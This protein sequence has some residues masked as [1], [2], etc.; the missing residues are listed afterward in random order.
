MCIC[1]WLRALSI[2]TAVTSMYL[3]MYVASS[4]TSLEIDWFRGGSVSILQAANCAALLQEED[5]L[6]EHGP[7]PCHR[8]VSGTQADC[9][10]NYTEVQV[11][12]NNFPPPR[13]WYAFQAVAQNAG[14]NKEKM[15]EENETT[16]TQL[17]KIVEEHGWKISKSMVKRARRTL[18]WTFHVSRYCHL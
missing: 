4:V 3:W 13:E 5:F 14:S 6:Q 9:V 7:V 11:T 12:W 2:N 18:G 1:V 17:V 10:G 8:R 15:K 16:M